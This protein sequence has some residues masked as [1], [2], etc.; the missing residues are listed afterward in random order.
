MT[1]SI[2]LVIHYRSTPY[3][4]DSSNPKPVVNVKNGH[5]WSRVHWKIEYPTC[6][7]IR[8]SIWTAG[9][10]KLRRVGR[11]VVLGC[12]IHR[13][14][15]STWGRGLEGITTPPKFIF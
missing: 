11:C 3:K 5:N 2:R 13:G 6:L 15:R 7:N 1:V 8:S 4:F 10:W 12:V 9:P 14:N